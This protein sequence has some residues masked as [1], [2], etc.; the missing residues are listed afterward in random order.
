MP[1]AQTVLQSCSSTLDIAPTDQATLLAA[2]TF[3]G[4]DFEDD[5][6]FA[7]A[8]QAGVTGIVPRDPRGFAES[9]IRVFTPADLVASLS[10]PPTP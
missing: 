4:P 7:C 2:Q 9:P 10:V 8:I 3:A 5:L 1:T 6:Q